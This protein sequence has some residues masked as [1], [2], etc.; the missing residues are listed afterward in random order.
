M[1]TDPARTLEDAQ[2]LEQEQTNDFE[3][4]FEPCPWVSNAV[5]APT[6]CGPHCARISLTDKESL[7]LLTWCREVGLDRGMEQDGA[8]S[9]GRGL[10]HGQT[11]VA[12]L[13]RLG[14][15]LQDRISELRNAV[16]QA[17][18]SDFNSWLVWH[19]RLPPTVV[20]F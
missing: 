16:Q 14:P 8:S 7:F 18:I 9:A 1:C 17:S 13:G 19:P 6:Q 15:F 10:Q 3:Q 2:K 12:R 4:G 5:L 11:L 20:L